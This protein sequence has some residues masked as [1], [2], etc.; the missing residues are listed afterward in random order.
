MYFVAPSVSEEDELYEEYVCE[1]NLVYEAVGD[2][3]IEEETYS[4]KPLKYCML[5]SRKVWSI[6]SAGLVTSVTVTSY[7][8]Q[9]V[10]IVT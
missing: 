1:T 8:H 6:V 2:R 3:L 7:S 9:K 4:G 5:H 10:T